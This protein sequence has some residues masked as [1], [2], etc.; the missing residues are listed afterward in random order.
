MILIGGAVAG[1][2]KKRTS[3][4][5]STTNTEY[6]AASERAKLAI[7]GSKLISQITDKPETAVPILLGDKKACI[8]LQ[9]G[10]SNTSN[11]KHVE[12]ACHHVVDEVIKGKLE[13]SWTNGDYMLADGLIKPLPWLAYSKNRGSI[14]V[15][16][17][18]EK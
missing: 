16:R 18:L 5:T 17:I 11:I 3:V 1:I 14:G 10:V 4:A 2:S 15:V 9:G 8:K 7:W 12:V 13:S 6:M